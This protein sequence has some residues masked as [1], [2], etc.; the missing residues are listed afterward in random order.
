MVVCGCLN[1]KQLIL[2]VKQLFKGIYL[3]F[4]LIFLDKTTV[5]VLNCY[6]GILC[7]IFVYRLVAAY[8]IAELQPNGFIKIAIITI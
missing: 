2:Y 1:N 7:Q 8:V 5:L 6:G 4:V 3:C